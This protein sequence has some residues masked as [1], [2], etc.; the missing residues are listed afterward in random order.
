MAKLLRIASRRSQLAMVQTHWVRDEL[1]KANPNLVISIEAMATQGDKIL[2][3]ALAKIGDK[4]LFTKELEAQMLVAQADIAVHS[5]KDLPT[6]LP[7]G[8][9]LGCIT[10][11]EDPA[12]ALVV[13]QKHQDKTLATLPEGSVV[14][15]SSLRRLAQ[16]RHH[17]PQL[18]FKDVRGNV[19][20]RLE[21][22]DAGEFDCLILAAAG[23]GRL[24]LGDRIHELIDASIS[25]HAVGQGALG[26][27]CRQG[28]DEVLAQIKL[29]EHLPTA[30]RCLAERAFLRELE[31]GCQVPIGVNSSFAE[32]GGDASYGSQD[33]ILTGMV[34]SLDGTKLIRDQARGSAA[35]PESIGIALALKLR[36]QG[37]GE[38]LEQI[39]ADVRPQA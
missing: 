6:N 23:L 33:L 10:E 34:A 13:H 19:I 29:L 1:V 5:L 4:G 12:D 39:F 20:T 32:A 37:A 31:G 22:L 3:V 15:T 21:K 18:L 38:I 26:I 36:E 16:L 11:R 17:Y 25:L 2:D 14:G 24:G 27:E 8:L 30:R 9:M 35:D 28:D 7:E